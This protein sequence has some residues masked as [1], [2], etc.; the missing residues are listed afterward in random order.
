MTS[1]E[2]QA[3]F[4]GRAAVVA[5][6]QVPVSPSPSNDLHPVPKRPFEG[7]GLVP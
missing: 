2:I 4:K 6:R 3:A 1:S 5:I 7:L